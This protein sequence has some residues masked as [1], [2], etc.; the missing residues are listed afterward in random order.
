[1]IFF[2]TRHEVKRLQAQ[3]DTLTDMLKVHFDIKYTMQD[4]STWQNRHP[5]ISTIPVSDGEWW[6]YGSI[7]GGSDEVMPATL[8]FRGKDLEIK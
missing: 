3:V 6:H 8:L 1:M 7:M 5:N 4:Y 2:K